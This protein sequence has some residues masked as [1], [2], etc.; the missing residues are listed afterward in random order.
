MGEK[1]GPL[2]VGKE[3][4]EGENGALGIKDAPLGSDGKEGTL[5]R[6]RWGGTAERGEGGIKVA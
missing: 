4:R 2:E 3:W 6:A 5:G 1:E